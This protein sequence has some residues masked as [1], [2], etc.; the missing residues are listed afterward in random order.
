M[1]GLV[2]LRSPAWSVYRI[3]PAIGLI[4]ADVGLAWHVGQ[5]TSRLGFDI[6]MKDT[7]RQRSSLTEI[8]PATVGPGGS[9]HCPHLGTTRASRQASRAEETSRFAAVRRHMAPI[10][11]EALCQTDA[12]PP[13]PVP[14]RMALRLTTR[15]LFHWWPSEIHVRQV[16][17]VRLN[18]RHVDHK[19]VGVRVNLHNVQLVLQHSL[20][21]RSDTRFGH[22][23][24]SDGCVQT[25]VRQL[26]AASEHIP[27]N[28]EWT[29]AN[30]DL[31]NVGMGSTTCGQRKKK[32]VQKWRGGTNARPNPDPGGVAD[33]RMSCAADFNLL[34]IGRLLTRPCRA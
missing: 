12:G 34:P 10:H 29:T 33:F 22:V 30:R 1:S 6:V 23:W 11:C 2:L 31:A 32:G 21:I 28:G 16:E 18:V 14:H 13:S 7:L 26:Q 17:C 5:I 27:A 9:K 25:A 8:Q 19:R 24:A 3:G 20:I 15:G 4:R